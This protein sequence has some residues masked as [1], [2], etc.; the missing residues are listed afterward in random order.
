MIFKGIH[1][2]SI[3]GNN[4]T[5]NKAVRQIV[6]DADFGYHCGYLILCISGL[7]VHPFFFSVLLFDVVKREETLLNVMKSVTRNGRSILLTAVFAII[8]V[9]LFSIVGFVFFQDDFR[10]EAE[11]LAGLIGEEIDQGVEGKCDLD[12]SAGDAAARY[13]APPDSSEDGESK[14]RSCDSLIMCIVTTLNQGLRNG[15]GIG[16]VLRQPSIEESLFA[17]RVI[18]DMLFFFIVIIIVLN[19]IFGVIIDTFADLRSEKQ[20]KEEV[21][22]NSCFICGKAKPSHYELLI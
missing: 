20:Q 5:F 7:F 19:L 11:P 22:K 14:E 8:L 21:L 17:A 16:D 10:N 1:L 15:G 3:M 4:G 9:Y 13:S 6:F 12:G 18:Y 2:I